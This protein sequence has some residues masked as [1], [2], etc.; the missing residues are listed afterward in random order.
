MM[1][2]VIVLLLGALL[3]S[4]FATAEVSEVYDF[5]TRAD[6]ERFQ[7]L[8]SEL[9]CPKCQNQNIADSNSPIS[10]D[11]RDEVYRMMKQGSTN[12]DIV[13]ALVSRFGE[14]V[15]YKP[16]V[17]H[18][19]IVLW[20]FPAIAVGGGLLIV[21]G[22]VLRARRRGDDQPVALNEDDR[23]RAERILADR[24]QGGDR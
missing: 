10:K 8:I 14:F 15:Q 21:A 24:D 4:P 12:D 17:D 22:I 13:G 23:L 3:F 6:E 11:M 9:R 1:R 20:A 18:R 5:D 16:P 19:T 2:A 7:E